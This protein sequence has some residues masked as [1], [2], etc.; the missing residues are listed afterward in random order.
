MGEIATVAGTAVGAAIEIGS[1]VVAGAI[2]SVVV[3]ATATAIVDDAEEV[4]EEAKTA[5]AT[6]DAAVATG[7][8]RALPIAIVGAATAAALV[9]AIVGDDI[10]LSER[11]IYGKVLISEK[12]DY[13]TH[14]SSSSLSLSLYCTPHSPFCF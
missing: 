9:I 1:A 10:I 11:F 2:G 6:D 13:C 8:A 5:T 4:E 7:A 3:A 14:S 12:S